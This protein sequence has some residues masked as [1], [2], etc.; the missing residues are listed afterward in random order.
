MYRITEMT[1]VPHWGG[2][3]DI[4]IETDSGADGTQAHYA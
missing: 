4:E 1:K 3:W 2:L